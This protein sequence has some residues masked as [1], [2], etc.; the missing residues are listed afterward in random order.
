MDEDLLAQVGFSHYRLG[1]DITDQM[2]KKYRNIL[3]VKS[4]YS[5]AKGDYIRG[6]KK[7]IG[8]RDRILKE[9]RKMLC[10]TVNSLD[11]LESGKEIIAYIN[12]NK[13]DKI[14]CII[15]DE[16][17]ALGAIYEANQNKIKLPKDL[18][19]AG[20]GN[21]QIVQ[22]SFPK[23]TTVDI[24]AYQIGKKAISQIFE[25]DNNIVTDTGYRFVKGETA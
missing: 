4:N 18:A 22:L 10:T 6:E 24:N 2:I 17:C 9:K 3:F 5:S 13:K 11:F 21:S 20:I 19:I 12:K 25:F 16:I 1:Y 8:Y 7:F 14:D 23:L 15:C